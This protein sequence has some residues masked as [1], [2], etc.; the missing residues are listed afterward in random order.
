MT[1]ACPVSPVDPFGD[2][3][4]AAPYPHYAD[5]RDAGAVVFLEH[6]GIWA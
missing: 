5:L 3:F 2:D 1:P 4:L 6:Y